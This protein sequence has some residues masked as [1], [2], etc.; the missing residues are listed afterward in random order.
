MATMHKREDN[1]DI[2]SMKEYEI[3]EKIKGI[4]K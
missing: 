1:L 3:T 4:I 2:E